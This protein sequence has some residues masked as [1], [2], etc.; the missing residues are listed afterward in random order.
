MKVLMGWALFLLILLLLFGPMILFSGLNPTSK[1]N[2]ITN[3]NF[4]VGIL[5]NGSTGNYYQLFVN[6][7]IA[8][9]MSVPEKS[10]E[11]FSSIASIVNSKAG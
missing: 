8:N 10:M 11:P 9:L 3:A 7:N 6:S 1:L 2:S 5:L 4:E